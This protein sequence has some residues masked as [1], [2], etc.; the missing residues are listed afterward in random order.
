VNVMTVRLIKRKQLLPQDEKRSQAPTPAKMALTTQGWIEEF[1]A[2]KARDQQ[3]LHGVL[4][5]G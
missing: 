3:T 2:R 1:R 5:R 4:K